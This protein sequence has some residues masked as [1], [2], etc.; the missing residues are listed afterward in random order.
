MK[1]ITLPKILDS[2][3]N[4]SPKIEVDNSVAERARV[5]VERMLAFS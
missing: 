2:L 4:M 5:T 3:T 1:L